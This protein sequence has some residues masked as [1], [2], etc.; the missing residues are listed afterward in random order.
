MTV[1][2]IDSFVTSPAMLLIMVLVFLFIAGCFVDTISLIVVLAPILVPVLNN[3]GINLIFFGI[4]AVL[5]S[6]IG[7]ISPPFGTNL[8][9]TMRVADKPFGYVAKSIV[10]FIII[11]LVFTVLIAFF[12]DI[13]LFLP[14]TMM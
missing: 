10:P 3:Y 5:C 6:Q 7:Y 8:F 1:A 9:V 12:P 11:V 2:F 4:L 14:N 13:V